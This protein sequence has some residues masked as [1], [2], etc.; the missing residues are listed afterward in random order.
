MKNIT[1]AFAESVLAYI[2]QGENIP[3]G[4]ASDVMADTV[5][6]RELYLS[7]KIDG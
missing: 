1:E 2:E 7:V 5:P 6:V 4:E 3:W